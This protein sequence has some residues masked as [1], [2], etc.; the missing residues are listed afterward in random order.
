MT[1]DAGV[2]KISGKPGAIQKLLLRIDLQDAAEPDK[3]IGMDLIEFGR[4]IGHE[5]RVQILLALMG[6]K[7]LPA[8]EL[9]YRAGVSSQTA[10]SHL[11]D[12]QNAGMIKVRKCGRFRYFEIA[13]NEVASLLE[14]LAVSLPDQTHPKPQSPIAPNLKKARFC[15]DHL[16]GELGVAVSQRLVQIGALELRDDRYSLPQGGHP[17]YKQL[18]IDLAA[19]VSKRRKTSPRCVDWSERLPHVAGSLGSAI[20]SQLLDRKYICRSRDDRS[21]SVSDEG[22]QFFTGTLGLNSIIFSAI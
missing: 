18:G 22:V 20:A 10:S 19:V 12:L 11:N 6:G 3:G 5:S 13:G 8:G 9:A 1:R 16:A 2:E 15:Y 7:A 4:M 21:V 17:I 14:G